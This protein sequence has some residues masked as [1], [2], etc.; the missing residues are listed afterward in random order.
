[1][2]PFTNFIYLSQQ[3]MHF[4]GISNQAKKAEW[5][6]KPDLNQQNHTKKIQKKQ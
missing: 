2:Y 5:T 3:R 6:T 4:G 1:M